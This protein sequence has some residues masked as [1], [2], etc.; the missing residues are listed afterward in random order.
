MA[1][2]VTL[3]VRRPDFAHTSMSSGATRGARPHQ[4]HCAR[5]RTVDECCG[6]QCELHNRDN[7]PVWKPP[8]G[9]RR[10]DAVH[11]YLDPWL[12]LLIDFSE[13]ADQSSWLDAGRSCSTVDGDSKV[14]SSFR[15]TSSIRPDPR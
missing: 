3:R 10:H 9:E 6:A 11:T 12:P 5:I 14:P 2:F 8:D 15:R 1:A 4:E 13:H 7:R